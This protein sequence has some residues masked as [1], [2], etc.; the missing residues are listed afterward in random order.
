[1]SKLSSFP[2]F[3]PQGKGKIVPVDAA[4]EFEAPR[5]CNL[6]DDN[7]DFYNDYEKYVYSK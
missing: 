6:E 2:P 3:S 1:M 5:Y 7:Y 4:F